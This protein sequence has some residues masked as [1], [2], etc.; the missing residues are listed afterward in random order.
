LC[1]VNESVA[2]RRLQRRLSREP[3]PEF[4]SEHVL[5]PI[6]RAEVAHT[7]LRSSVTLADITPRESNGRDDRL[8]VACELAEWRG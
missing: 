3:A 7:T 4:A 5:K 8:F 2:D 6:E 1:A